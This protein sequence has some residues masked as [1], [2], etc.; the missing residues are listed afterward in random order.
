M[1]G[2]IRE[3]PLADIWEAE[4]A[5]TWRRKLKAGHLTGFCRSCDY[6]EL[7]LGGCSNARLAMNGDIYSENQLCVYRTSAAGEGR[8]SGMP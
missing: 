8:Y 3:R 2:S 1:E 7:C 5:F 6:G 4:N